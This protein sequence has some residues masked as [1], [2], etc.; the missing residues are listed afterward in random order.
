MLQPTWHRYRFA[1]IV[2]KNYAQKA[3]E[4]SI[5][6]GYG[7]GDVD[8]ANVLV[9]NMGIAPIAGLHLPINYFDGIPNGD[10][11][12]A[13]ALARI[14]KIRKGDL[15]VKVI[16]A[17]GN[18]VTGAKVSVEQLKHR[19]HFGTAVQSD[20][21]VGKSKADSEYRDTVT[22]LFNTV[23]FES[24]M[25]WVS[26]GARNP[27]QIEA[28]LDWLKKN[29]INVRGTNLIWGGW[30]YLPT[31]M[32]TMSKSDCLALIHK[33]VTEAMAKYK[34]KVY[35]WDV[36]NEAVGQHAL[37]DKIGYDA[38]PQV[39]QWAKEA[40][41]N[42]QLAYNDYALTEELSYGPAYR[43]RVED[44]LQQ[45][46]SAGG[47]VDVL[48][49][50][51]HQVVPMTPIWRV[52][53]I[54]D[55]LDKLNLNLEVTENDLS[56]WNDSV[57]AEYMGDYLTA[58]FSH[59]SVQGFTIWGFWEK[60]QWRAKEG[61]AIIN[62]DFSYRPAAAVWENLVKHQWWTNVSGLTDS[63]GDYAARGFYGSYRVSVESGG[64]TTS[65]VIQLV[66]G[67]SQDV[68]ITFK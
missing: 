23:V 40:D 52:I 29:D 19:F 18:P 60:T 22:K 44:L 35:V 10:G 56:I 6:L 21:L 11:W 27:G 24:E 8:I 45:I 34:G 59:P 14:E 41:P 17:V 25:K 13:D 53:E 12:K 46:E 62:D 48:G 42:V 39:Y 63:S 2:N 3:A 28:S 57:Q 58:L 66:P 65:E 67:P 51:S 5:F 4:L 38:I 61:A 7:K 20:V 47:P 32:K 49:M 43:G 54:L 26:L 9:Q 1:A 37:W 31:E 64:V 16:D 33:R 30:Q 36:V 50:E 55:E 68:T 15:T